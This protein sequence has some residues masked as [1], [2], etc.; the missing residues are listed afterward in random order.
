MS[1]GKTLE[2]CFDLLVHSCCYQQPSGAEM[3]NFALLTLKWLP[4]RACMRVFVFVCVLE[5]RNNQLLNFYN[6]TGIK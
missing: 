3:Y 2:A 5:F 1:V 6:V 4:G